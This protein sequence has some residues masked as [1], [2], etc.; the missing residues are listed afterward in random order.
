M[1]VDRLT[2][3]FIWVDHSR[4][5]WPFAFRKAPNGTLI[6]NPVASVS[7]QLSVISYQLSVISYQLSVI[8]TDH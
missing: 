7:F 8:S 1:K 5:E 2:A 6:S 4:G 3:V